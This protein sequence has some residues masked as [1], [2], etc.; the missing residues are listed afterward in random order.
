MFVCLEMRRAALLVS[1]KARQSGY[2][3]VPWRDQ[4][5]EEMM[6]VCLVMQREAPLVSEKG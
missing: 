1:E 6:V 4:Q 5:S 2:S 3:M